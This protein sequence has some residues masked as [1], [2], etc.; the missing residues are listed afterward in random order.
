M[1]K[2]IYFLNSKNLTEELKSGTFTEVRALK[3]LIIT[4]IIGRF[5]FE[6]PVMIDFSESEVSLWKNFAEIAFFII[7]GFITYYGLWLT[8]Q[9]NQKGDGKDFFLRLTSLILPIGLKLVIYFLMIG[10]ILGFIATLLVSNLGMVG[11]VA[12][13]VSYFIAAMAFYLIFY[14]QLRNQIAIVSGFENV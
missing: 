1:F 14:I 8:Y 7:L 6:F 9:A 4:A 11:V 10:L 2:D 12:S 5:S 3:H 13:V